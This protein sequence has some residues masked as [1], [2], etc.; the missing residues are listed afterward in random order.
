MT[1]INRP[2]LTASLINLVRKDK[3]RKSRR[4]ALGRFLY[5]LTQS[6]GNSLFA[7][8][9]MMLA[10]GVVHHEWIVQCPTI[11]YW[12]AVLLAYLLRTALAPFKPVKSDSAVTS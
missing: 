4:K 8:L 3:A 2:D 7:G 10:V 6:I 9:W 11:G 1:T 5:L 12:W